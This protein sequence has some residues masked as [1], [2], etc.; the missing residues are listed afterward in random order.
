MKITI[1]YTKDESLKARTVEEYL[2]AMF[3]GI[4]VRESDKHPPY[5]HTYLTTKRPEKD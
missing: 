5:F 3:P 1:C 4:K 2:R